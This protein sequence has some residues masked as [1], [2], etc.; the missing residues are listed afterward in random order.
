MVIRNF[1]STRPTKLVV[2]ASRIG[3]GWALL[4]EDPEDE[5][6]H[7]VQC[8]SR[9]L[10]SCKRNYSICELEMLGATHAILKCRHWLLGLSG[11]KLITDHKGLIGTFNKPISEVGNARQRNFREKLQEYVFEAVWRKGVNKTI[12]IADCIS[13]NPLFKDN[14][15]DEDKPEED[16]KSCKL[17]MC[18][19]KNRCGSVTTDEKLHEHDP[20]LSNLIEEAGKCKKYKALH[21]VILQY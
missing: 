3:L 20:Q 16:L 21:T 7:R 2:D 1:E 19:L 4:Q 14:S 12:S 8:G 17:D 15:I 5:E 11:W 13:R 9:T 10:S 18:L 6:W